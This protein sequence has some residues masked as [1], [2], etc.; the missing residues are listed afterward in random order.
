MPLPPLYDESGNVRPPTDPDEPFRDMARRLV[1]AHA[2]GWSPDSI[3]GKQA[4]EEFE[5]FIRETQARA[6][7]ALVPWWE[8]EGPMSGP[9]WWVEVKADAYAEAIREGL[10]TISGKRVVP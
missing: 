9:P 7:E 3:P 1:Q 8:S 2:G 5:A 4:M 10:T 6:V